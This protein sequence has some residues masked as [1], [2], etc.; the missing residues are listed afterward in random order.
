[1]QV[2]IENSIVF[3][4]IFV[5]SIAIHEFAHLFGCWIFKCRLVD[6]KVPFFVL[7]RDGKTR[8]TFT[9]KE[10]NHCSFATTSKTKAF[11][12]TL[13]GPFIDLIIGLTLLVIYLNGCLM[14]GILLASIVIMFYLIYN[15]LPSTN[16]DGALLYSL[17]KEK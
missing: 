8:C 11:C 1:M 10:H 9:L 3:S 5:C 16:G 12:V 2:V 14:W 7:Y 13:L 15:L 17:F 4:L 6:L